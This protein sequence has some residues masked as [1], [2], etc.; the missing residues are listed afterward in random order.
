ML[1]PLPIVKRCRAQHYEYEH[2]SKC[3]NL[4]FANARSP[5]HWQRM[6]L[7]DSILAVVTLVVLVHASV[8]FYERDI[9]GPDGTHGLLI[10]TPTFLHTVNKACH[11][12]KQTVV[13]VGQHRW[14]EYSTCGRRHRGGATPF[15][16]VVGEDVLEPNQWMTFYLW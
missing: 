14:W 2:N 7:G 10:E 16:E 8:S 5:I 15:R 11:I 3:Q 12:S 6:R 4:R 9:H 1:R 13:K